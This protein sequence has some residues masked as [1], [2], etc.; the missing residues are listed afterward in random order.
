MRKLLLS[1]CCM[2]FMTG[3]LVAAEYTLVSFDK[4]TKTLT[5]KDK[6]GKEVKAKFTDKTK[7]YRIDKDGNKVEGKGEFV[8]KGLED[9]EKVAGRKAE[10]TID[11]DEITEYTSKGG[12]GK[13]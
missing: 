3:L 4:D 13:N 11:K 8:L 1:L 12:K 6:D 5:V 2:L 7:F 10:I 9:K